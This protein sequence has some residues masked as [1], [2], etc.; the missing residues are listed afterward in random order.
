M[1]DTNHRVLLGDIFRNSTG[2]ITP[3][4]LKMFGF[5]R[6]DLGQGY[7]DSEA[8]AWCEENNIGDF[9]NN[10]EAFWFNNHEDA[11]LFKLRWG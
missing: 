10:S 11:V 9:V 1:Q 6:V 7:I 4:V 8:K 2:I 5:P 3:D